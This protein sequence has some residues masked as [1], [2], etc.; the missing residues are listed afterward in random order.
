MLGGVGK[1][2]A[3]RRRPIL[4]TPSRG[5]TGR[6]RGLRIRATRPALREHAGRV[7]SLPDPRG[8]GPGVC[9][10]TR[11][12]NLKI[13]DDTREGSAFMS[14]RLNDGRQKIAIL[15]GGPASLAAAFALTS[16]EDWASRYDITIYQQGFRLGGKLMS[17][18]NDR[19][20]QRVEEHGFHVVLG[21]Y[22]NALKMLRDCYAE[23][24]YNVEDAFQS[25]Q[26]LDLVEKLGD[27]WSPWPVEL[28]LA[29]DG[30][31]SIDAALNAPV[32]G[33]AIRILGEHLVERAEKDNPS[34]FRD[35]LMGLGDDSLDAVLLRERGWEALPALALR[36]IDDRGSNKGLG[37]DYEEAVEAVDAFR[38]R[39]WAAHGADAVDPSRRRG[40]IVC[41]L[42]STIFRGV[43]AEQP[44]NG[45]PDWD[46]LD[47]HDLRVWLARHGAEPAAIASPLVD[48]GYRLTFSA[49]ATPAGGGL[50]A[51][52]AIRGL[53]EMM[54][55]E[56]ALFHLPKGGMGEVFVAPMYRL[57][58][59]RGVK[60]ELF[61][62]VRD[63]HVSAGA[64]TAIDV[65]RQVELLNGAY[66]PLLPRSDGDAAWREH[67]PTAPRYEQIKDG[68]EL[69]R[70]RYDL[71]S[72][73]SAWEQWRGCRPERLSQ[74]EHF[75]AVILGIPASALPFACPSLLAASAPLAATVRGLA[76]TATRS[77]QLWLTRPLDD[78]EW[79]RTN[80][81]LAVCPG[82][83]D[84]WADM[85]G[86]LHWEGSPRP[87]A[88]VYLCGRMDGELPSAPESSFAAAVQRDTGTETTRW[89]S[90]SL[91]Y[92][93]PAG[94]AAREELV[95][96]IYARA[97]V[98]PSER[99]IQCAP[100][101]ST[102]RLDTRGAGIGNLYLAGDWT[103]T[104]LN[105]G[106]I[107]A[108]VMSG[109]QAAEAILP[110]KEPPK[111]PPPADYAYI[112]VDGE[113]IWN[114]PFEYRDATLYLFVVQ[115]PDRSQLEVLCNRYLNFDPKAEF[116]YRAL[117]DFLVIQCTRATQATTLAP[118]YPER[119][120]M[121]P[122][123]VAVSIPVVK[124][125][126]ETQRPVALQFF[127]PYLF[128][129]TPM[130][131]ATGR[132]TYGVFKL[133]GAF[134]I[135][136]S[137]PQQGPQT[138]EVST[139]V[140]TQQRTQV[141]QA[142]VLRVTRTNAVATAA[143]PTD[144]PGLVGK[145][146]FEIG[147]G[148]RRLIVQNSLLPH[149]ILNHPF[150]SMVGL[151]QFRDL[152]NPTMA[153][154]KRIVEPPLTV[155]SDT[156]GVILDSSFEAN[157]LANHESMHIPATLGLPENTGVPVAL[158]VRI[159]FPS[160]RIGATRTR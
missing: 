122:T 7:A 91:G 2:W 9:S 41:N 138:V 8:N 82:A 96:S 155:A 80:G 153:C 57:L 140:I 88:L 64:V 81:V 11:A 118:E 78:S 48:A 13:G 35:A 115:S 63:I 42:I 77:A 39:H 147:C 6:L 90:Q 47:E 18:R 49:D 43:C 76:T 146:V 151:Q 72:P 108:A 24:S 31:K 1:V 4:P 143:A 120:Y 69:E 124:R 98:T 123:A 3:A 20:H 107:E 160:Y 135:D 149:A 144:L 111:P 25:V 133:P 21:F 70:L 29:P 114:G 85:T 87:Q 156:S 50:A 55:V 94:D 26:R 73:W 93:W 5:I 44:V 104:P 52:T 59:R 125:E 74:G 103:R 109:F 136:W 139:P 23:L 79:K 89:L 145:M 22:K 152:D 65:L 75:D 105:A 116:E 110:K 83:F 128:V 14:E 17:G 67:W 131:M 127:S 99:Y 19:E 68:A 132:E 142:T 30:S 54:T 150:P 134:D 95:A 141:T 86:A 46:K 154:F 112:Q 101:T 10:Q 12:R 121:S 158:A 16:R 36:L 157:F 97:N 100:G 117:G 45:E 51:G 32:N 33:G 15:G 106:C 148:P 137:D 113:P 130:E 66:A 92:I 119:G 71:E 27:K 61:T 53:V 37:P 102:L 58:S 159:H 34:G 84:T 126:R 40:A 62:C 56:N 38:V 129:D 60:F 28:P